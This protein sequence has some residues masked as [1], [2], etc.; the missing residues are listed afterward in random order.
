MTYSCNV[1]ASFSLQVLL[2]T[3]VASSASSAATIV[4]TGPGVPSIFEP[5]TNLNV[6][7]G[8]RIAGQFVIRDTYVVESIEGWFGDGGLTSSTAAGEITFSIYDQLNGFPN[9]LVDSRTISSPML[10]KDQWF[11]A[12]SLDWLLPPGEYWV[13]YEVPDYST[14]RAITVQNAPFPLLSYATFDSPVFPGV[15][16]TDFGEFSFSTRIEGRLIVP[17]VNPI[18]GFLIGLMWLTKFSRR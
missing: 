18:V 16:N 8:T 1:I 15:W 4:D 2:A 14:F 7:S 12:S 10:G 6:R 13:A 9:A 3:T 17:L 5:Y 11:G